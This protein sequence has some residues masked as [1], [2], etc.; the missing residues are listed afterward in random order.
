[1]RVHNDNIF[2]WT[3]HGKPLAELLIYLTEALIIDE[4]IS[5]ISLQFSNKK[6]STK[7]SSVIFKMTMVPR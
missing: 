7:L 3:K 2:S 6:I 1:M 5:K 4:F